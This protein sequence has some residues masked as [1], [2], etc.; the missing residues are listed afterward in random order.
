MGF[1]HW[2]FYRTQIRLMAKL[3]IKHKMLNLRPRPVARG[4]KGALIKG[5]L[6]RG[7][8]CVLKKIW[9]LGFQCS[10]ALIHKTV[11]IRVILINQ[12]TSS[13]RI[14][15]ELQREKREGGTS[16]KLPHSGTVRLKSIVKLTAISVDFGSYPKWQKKKRCSR[17]RENKWGSRLISQINI[18]NSTT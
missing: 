13:H 6:N 3:P 5:K 17:N 18:I 10:K 1:L 15:Q 4:G 9:G 8:Q 2:V 12:T 16:G 11:G 14:L 7:K